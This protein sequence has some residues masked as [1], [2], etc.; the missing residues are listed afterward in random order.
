MY[1]G[2]VITPGHLV[3]AMCLFVHV[4]VGQDH[5]GEK[6]RAVSVWANFSQNGIASMA[7]TIVDICST[8]TNLIMSFP[9]ERSSVSSHCFQDKA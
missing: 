1:L 6:H 4:G 2:H 8:N 3:L 9:I 5:N 7:D